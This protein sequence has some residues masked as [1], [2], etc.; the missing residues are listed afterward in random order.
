MAAQSRVLPGVSSLQVQGEMA[1]EEGQ[2][3]T[4]GEMSTANTPS[5]RRVMEG[6]TVFI[7]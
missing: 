2:T 5:N 4:L 3:P 1:V 7:F 6:D